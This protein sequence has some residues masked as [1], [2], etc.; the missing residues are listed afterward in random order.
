M[1]RKS[2]PSDRPDPGST[3]RDALAMLAHDL[4][5]PLMM[6][7]GEVAL[8]RHAE[9]TRRPIARACAAIDRHVSQIAAL[10]SDLARV[11]E[12]GALD[13]S[14]PRR[15]FDLQELIVESVDA[16]SK[17]GELRSVHMALSS[18]GT[19]AIVEGNRVRLAQAFTSVLITAAKCAKSGGTIRV[20]LAT[21][22]GH[23]EVGVWDTGRGIPKNSLPKL[24]DRLV[25]EENELPDELG[26]GMVIARQIIGAHEGVLAGRTEGI[27]FGCQF[28]VRLPL[29]D[30][31]NA[32][33]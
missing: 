16:V 10:V 12:P 17:L 30:A 23:V 31:L 28:I 1:H 8:L 18:R 19:A 29:A 3:L 25:A 20:S 13:M 26:V 9:G 14:G 15:R 11:A 33:G 2:S 22:E 4:R 32:E 5:N 24:F 6:I 21:E 7:R 27:G